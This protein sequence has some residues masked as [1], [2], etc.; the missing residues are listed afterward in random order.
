LNKTKRLNI[1][2][3]TRVQGVNQL[4]I[5]KEM[6]IDTINLANFVS[7]SGLEGKVVF[8]KPENQEKYQSILKPKMD[9]FK[10]KWGNNSNV[11]L[12]NF[13]KEYRKNHHPENFASRG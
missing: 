11:I 2:E 7:E 5:T 10:K 1:L 4:V 6:V 3:L 9:E 13:L 12:N 8:N